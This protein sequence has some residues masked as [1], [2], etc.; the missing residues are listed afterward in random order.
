MKSYL[1]ILCPSIIL[2]SVTSY[3][4][5]TSSWPHLRCDVGLKEGEDQQNCL[6]TAVLY[7]FIMVHNG[8]R[9]SYMLVDC[10]EL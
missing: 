10:I 6:C 4:Y 9:S 3:L 2:L 5:L 7:T 8:T 1:G